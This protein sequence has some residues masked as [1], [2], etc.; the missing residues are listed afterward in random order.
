MRAIGRLDRKITIQSLAVTQG[1]FGEVTEAYSTF[2]T[3]WAQVKEV[4]GSERDID[5]KQVGLAKVEFLIRHIDN[6]NLRMRISYD[7]KVYD[8]THIK[9]HHM[10]R[11]NSITITAEEVI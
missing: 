9:H 8:I 3:V 7:S 6:L 1:D 10:D 2:A 5:D 4:S 11:D